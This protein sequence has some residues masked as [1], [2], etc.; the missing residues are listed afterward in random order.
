MDGRA[1]SLRAFRSDL[2]SYLSRMNRSSSISS[3]VSP[4]EKEVVGGGLFEGLNF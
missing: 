3:E 4:P 1:G 2:R